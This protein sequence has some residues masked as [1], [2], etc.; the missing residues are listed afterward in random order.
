MENADVLLAA[1][2]AGGIVCVLIEFSLYYLFNW[3]ILNDRVGEW[4]DVWRDLDGDGEPDYQVVDLK[5]LLALALSLVVV[6]VFE[7][8]LVAI[9]LTEFVPREISVT[10]V[11][12]LITAAG[13]AGGSTKYFKMMRRLRLPKELKT[14]RAQG[15]DEDTNGVY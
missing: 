15:Y 5:P 6:F 7:F 11:G 4:L 10:V 1:L 9:V 2:I 12:E 14:L 3:T 8:D 13:L